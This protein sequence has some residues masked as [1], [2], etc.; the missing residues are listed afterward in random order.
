M[1]VFFAALSLLQLSLRGICCAH[2]EVESEK[3]WNGVVHLRG[4][5][6][7]RFAF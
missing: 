1:K 7:D 5:I 6:A 2:E 3:E 4:I